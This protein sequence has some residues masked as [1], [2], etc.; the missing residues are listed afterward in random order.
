MAWAPLVVLAPKKD[1]GVCF[2][3]DYRQLN[4]QATFDTYPMPCV[5]EIFDSVRAAHVMPTLDLAKGYWQIP[6]SSSSR[7]KTA[8]VTPFGLYEFE[9]PYFF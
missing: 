9:V 6:M 7:E 5:E 3:A 1:G 4:D 8:F 2:C